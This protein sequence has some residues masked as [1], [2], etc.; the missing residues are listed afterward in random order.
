MGLWLEI[1]LGVF[2]GGVLL[3]HWEWVLGVVWMLVAVT[4]SLLLTALGW[5]FLLGGDRYF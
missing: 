5:Y 1:A 2:V 3:K 4:A